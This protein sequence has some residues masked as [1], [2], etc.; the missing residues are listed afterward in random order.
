MIRTGIVRRIDDLGRVVIP[1]EIRESFIIKEGD[2]LEITLDGNKICLELYI[3]RDD[4]ED[5]V[6][7]IIEML[8]TDEYIKSNKEMAISALEFAKTLLRSDNN[9]NEK[10]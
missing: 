10:S 8:K 2:P 1:K 4:Y 9:S 7:R 5:R 6:N 3:P